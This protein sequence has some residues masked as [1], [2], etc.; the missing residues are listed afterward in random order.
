MSL[1]PEEARHGL[2]ALHSQETQ[3]D[4]VVDLKLFTPDAGWTWFVTEGQPDG[5]DFRLFG[6]VIGLEEEWGYF[7]LSQLSAV[8]G[9]PGLPVERDLRFSPAPFSEVRARRCRPSP[10]PCSSSLTRNLCAGTPTWLP[11]A[12]GLSRR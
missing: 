7:L 5:E 10:S 9:P 11:P 12:S 3:R 2:P 1:L 6:F 8:R 4:P